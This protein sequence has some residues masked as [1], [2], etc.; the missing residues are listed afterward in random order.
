MKRRAHDTGR[1]HAVVRS[2]MEE[3]GACGGES[4]CRP[5]GMMTDGVG[6]LERGKWNRRKR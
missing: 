5:Y 4:T 1:A 2:R 6:P 3:G